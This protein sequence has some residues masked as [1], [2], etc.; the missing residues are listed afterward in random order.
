MVPFGVPAD[1]SLKRSGDRHSIFICQVGAWCPWNPNPEDVAESE[2]T[3]TQLN[4][5]MKAYKDQ[6]QLRDEEYAR[7]KQSAMNKNITESPDVWVERKKGELASGSTVADAEGKAGAPSI[8]VEVVPATPALDAGV[9][10]ASDQVA[11]IKI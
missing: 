3:E 7:R 9:Y 11:S 1:E 6:E 2:Y 8:G 4:T 5:L 10:A